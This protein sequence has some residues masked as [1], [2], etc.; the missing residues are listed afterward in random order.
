MLGEFGLVR[1]WDCMRCSEG[2]GAVRYVYMGKMKTDRQYRLAATYTHIDRYIESPAE[3]QLPSSRLQTRTRLNKKK[4][5]YL[6]RRGRIFHV[7]IY[8]PQEAKRGG[9]G[10]GSAL[11]FPFFFFFFFLPSLAIYLSL[12]L[13]LYTCLGI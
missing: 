9:G 6:S 13:S 11:V 8:Q 3:Q 4:F 7:R 12:S 5:I 2:C 10:T 1:R